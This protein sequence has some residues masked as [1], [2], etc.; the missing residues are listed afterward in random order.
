[1]CQVLNS[2]LSFTFYNHY[3]GGILIP[4]LQMKRLRLKEISAFG[5]SYAGLTACGTPGDIRG[6][7][8]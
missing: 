7:S 6:T 8:Q 2:F 3:E 4:V 5:Q 1:M